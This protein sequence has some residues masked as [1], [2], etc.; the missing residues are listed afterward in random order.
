VTWFRVDD[1]LTDH[2]KVLALGKDMLPAMGLWT[3]V[4]AWAGRYDTDGYVPESI[5]R[6]HDPRLRLARRLVD[7]GLWERRLLDGNPAFYYH[8]WTD[9][10]PSKDEIERKREKARERQRRS[11]RRRAGLEPT[12]PGAGETPPEEDDAPPPPDDDEI[13]YE[14]DVTP[15]VTRDT[16]RESR[17]PDPTRPVPTYGD[18]GRGGSSTER[19]RARR[20][21]PEGQIG[22][23]MLTVVAGGPAL[24]VRCR[25]HEAWPADRPVPACRPCGDA[26]KAAESAHASAA[27]SE[28]RRRHAFRAAVDACDRCDENGRRHD[29]LLP[30]ECSAHLR[31]PTRATG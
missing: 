24:S 15:D 13:D 7:V 30:C 22:M 26:R 3:I 25:E 21:V 2:P 1:N 19:G 29:D 8:D 4:G 18:L 9:S 28:T 5:V 11:R 17:S 31:G 10:Q 6:R 14:D 20:A 12:P 16:T 23:P 27:A